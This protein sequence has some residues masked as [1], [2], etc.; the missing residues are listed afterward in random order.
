[1]CCDAWEVLMLW[2]ISMAKALS[3]PGSD[4]SIR[5][6]W[7]GCWSHFYFLTT[8]CPWCIHPD[9]PQDHRPLRNPELTPATLDLS[10]E[11]QKR[12]CFLSPDPKLLPS[13]RSASRTCHL[14]CPAHYLS[15]LVVT[16]SWFVTLFVTDGSLTC[17]L[18]QTW[19]LRACWVLSFKLISV[20]TT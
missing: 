15:S 2:H 4:I 18:T 16:L 10:G 17:L 11:V 5:I 7:Q 12:P 14:A 3:W 1:M 20:P 6:P 8:H 19:T 13:L 9:P